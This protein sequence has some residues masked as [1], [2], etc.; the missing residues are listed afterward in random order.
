[1]IAAHRAARARCTNFGAPPRHDLLYNA[2]ART[3][4]SREASQESRG[5]YYPRSGG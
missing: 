5:A 2:F 3:S 4:V 1:M